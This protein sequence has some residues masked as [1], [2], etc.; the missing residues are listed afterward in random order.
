MD[1]LNLWTKLENSNSDLYTHFFYFHYYYY[2]YEKDT[3]E[4]GIKSLLGAS[5]VVE[6]TYVDGKD[7]IIVA[8]DFYTAKVSCVQ[9]FLNE[10]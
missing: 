9:V 1:H 10:K 3:L 5:N 7:P 6:F 4:E 8:K 2:R